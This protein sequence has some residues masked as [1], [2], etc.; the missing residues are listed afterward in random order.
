M[1]HKFRLNPTFQALRQK[2][3]QLVTGKR[4]DLPDR[5]ELDLMSLVQEIEVQ[6]VELELQNQ[7]LRQAFQELEASRNQYFEL[8]QTAPVAFVTVNEKG[9]IVRINEAAARLL[10]GP[11]NFLI[12]RS[13]A[14]L[15]CPEDQRVYFAF[16]QQYA[17]RQAGN[18]CELRLKSRQGEIVHVHMEAQA[19]DDEQGK[20]RQWRF[21]M[22]DITSLKRIEEE[23]RQSRERLEARVAQRTAE[24]EQRN[25]QLARL[26]SEL[27]L[28]EQRER[29]R[30][31]DLLHDHMQQLLAGARLNLEMAAQENTCPHHSAFKNA[32]DL[33]DQSLET[34]RTLSAELSPPV[35]YTQGLAEALKWLAR[36]ME[37]IHQLHV[38]LDAEPEA[39]PDQ[40]EIK[41]LLFQ[42]V[43]ELLF[44]VVKHAGVNA[45]RVAMRRQE[46]RIVIVVGDE[47]SGFHPAEMS[48]AEDRRSDK[49]GFGLF[50][51]RERLQLLGGA[52]DIESHPGRGATMTLTAPLRTSAFGLPEPKAVPAREAQ[53]PTGRP[54]AAGQCQPNGP[55]RVM[56]VDDHA[57]MRQGLSALL[58]WHKDI[59]IVG[60]AADGRQAVE[61]APH[62]DPDVILMDISMPVMDGVEATRRIHAQFPHIRIIALSMHAAEEMA[63][64][65]KAAGAVA[66]LSKTDSPDTIISAI[67]QPTLH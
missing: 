20:H 46:G 56:L 3:E 49:T 54:K 33:V 40:E 9:L 55:I 14:A 58:A 64:E 36:W 66:Y 10:G 24:L 41:V 34:S 26:T 60:E 57:V 59:E 67:R 23:L 51:I 50:N 12:G 15:I 7:E 29:R 19:I 42:S 35:L 4:I 38:D 13:L 37:K 63:A 52:F 18:G 65:I 30:L 25:Q 16:L 5:D 62:L 48:P 6:H 21:G 8:Y 47:G 17:L 39:D 31:A 28:A 32:C 22:I 44:N 53:P 45:A 43:R 27:T 11:A 2:A 61:S 1:N